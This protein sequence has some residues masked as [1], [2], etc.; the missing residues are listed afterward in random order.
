MTDL[1]KSF[2]HM[3][4]IWAG[5]VDSDD[6]SIKVTDSEAPVTVLQHPDTGLTYIIRPHESRPGVY[7]LEP[8]TESPQG[9]KEITQ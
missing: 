5:A 3:K 2:K 9:N 8:Q 6:T 7:I 1:S 4:E